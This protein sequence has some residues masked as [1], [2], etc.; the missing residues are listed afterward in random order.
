MRF[1][2][3]GTVH[4]VLEWVQLDQFAGRLRPLVPVDSL[5]NAWVIDRN[6]IQSLHSY[7]DD[8]YHYMCAHHRRSV[9]YVAS[10][11][12][13]STSKL[14]TFQIAPRYCVNE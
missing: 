3:D 5:N 7:G 6:I 13:A 2:H 10:A 12:R 9:T 4:S 1:V 11:K 14:T 8:V